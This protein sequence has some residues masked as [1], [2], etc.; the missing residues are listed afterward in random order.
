VAAAAAL[1]LVLLLAGGWRPASAG[2]LRPSGRSTVGSPSALQQD[3]AGSSSSST[4]AAGSSAT[5]QRSG[6]PVSDTQDA[7]VGIII[8]ALIIVA[9]LL[10]ICFL[11][12][13]RMTKPVPVAAIAVAGSRR[14]QGTTSSGQGSS[15]RKRPSDGKRSSGRRRSR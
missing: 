8:I 2:S 10:T 9:L 6:D 4:T 1:A 3:P 5:V 15:A 7:E 11:V 14:P 12:F 13:W